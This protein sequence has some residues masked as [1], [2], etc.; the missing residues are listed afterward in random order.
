MGW[1]WHRGPYAPKA[2]RIHSFINRLSMTDPGLVCQHC[3]WV[4]ETREVRLRDLGS[5]RWG[6]R[7]LP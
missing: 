4:A 3:G 1:L 2:L 6:K 7:L 5:N